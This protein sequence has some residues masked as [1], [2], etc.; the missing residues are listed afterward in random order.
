MAAAGWRPGWDLAGTVERAAADGSGPRADARVV[1]MLN[2]GAWAE[3]VAVPTDRLAA[4]P[5]KVTFSQAATFPVAGLTALYALAKG[6]LLLGRR[7]GPPFEGTWDLPGGFLEAGETPERALRRELWEEL[8]IRVGRLRLLGFYTDRYGSGGVPLLTAVYRAMPEP[9]RI[10]PS[11]DVSE[12]RW[13]PLRALPL[14]EIAFRRLHRL[15]HRGDDLVVEHHVRLHAPP[16]SRRVACARDALCA[17]VRGRPSLRVHHRDLPD[18]SPSV[19]GDEPREG[20]PGRDPFSHQQEA[21]R[22]V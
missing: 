5:D 1:G 17:R 6:G 11:D 22:P 19:G 18:V 14:R 3:R 4:L 7:A 13:F 9:G 2:E 20:I 15:R 10:R 12:V 8:G 21:P 16:V